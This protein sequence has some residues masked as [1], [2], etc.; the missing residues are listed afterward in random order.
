MGEKMQAEGSKLQGTPLETTLTFESVKSAA[1]FKQVQQQQQQQ[2]QSG[3]GGGI[4]GMFASKL[5]PKPGPA[6]QRSKVMTT[7]HAVLSLDTTVTPADLAIPAGFKEK[8]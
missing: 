3:G 2:Q 6:E 7:T 8:K 4:G 5:G 1:E